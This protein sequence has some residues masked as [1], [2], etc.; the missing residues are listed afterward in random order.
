MEKKYLNFFD[1]ID[2]TSLDKENIRNE[3]LYKKSNNTIHKL[4][5]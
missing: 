2:L 4:L 1:N 3:I 5:L